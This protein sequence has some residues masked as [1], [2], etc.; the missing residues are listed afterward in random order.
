[1]EYPV[2]YLKIA[3]RFKFKG[4]G[5]HLEKIGQDEQRNSLGI[6]LRSVIMCRL[7]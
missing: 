4:G 7:T 6:A 3:G 5:G 1:M 2:I